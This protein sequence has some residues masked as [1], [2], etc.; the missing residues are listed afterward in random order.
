MSRTIKIYQ[1]GDSWYAAKH[2]RDAVREICSES[3]NPK[4][5]VLEDVSELPD[6]DLDTLEFYY[7][8]Y[9]DDSKVCTFRERLAEIISDG[10][11]KFPTLFA[12]EDF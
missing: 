8:L 2:L 12:S 5:E 7:D 9:A 10:K 3:G 11:T 1:Y 6:S 4:R